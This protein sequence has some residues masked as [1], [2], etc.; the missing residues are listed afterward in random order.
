MAVKV[1]NR[2]KSTHILRKYNDTRILASIEIKASKTKLIDLYHSIGPILY[3]FV[4]Q[5]HFNFLF[6]SLLYV[7]LC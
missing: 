7:I 6:V 2:A 5:F 3:S 4:R 1:L